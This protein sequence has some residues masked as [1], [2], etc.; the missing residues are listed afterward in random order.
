MDKQVLETQKAE[1]N[2]EREEYGAW[3]N[4][5]LTLKKGN[6]LALRERLEAAEQDAKAFEEDTAL[7]LSNLRGQAEMLEKLLKP[8]APKT[9]NAGMPDVKKLE[10]DNVPPTESEAK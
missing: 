4:Q 9:D 2:K 7:R 8:D 5:Q 6:V 10:G 3:A 1:V